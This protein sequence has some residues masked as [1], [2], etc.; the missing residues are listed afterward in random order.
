MLT[1]RELEVL[2]LRTRGKNQKTIAKELDI[3]Q[4]A[5]SQ[6]EKSAKDKLIQAEK[7]RELLGKE[8]ISVIESSIG[9]KVVWGEKK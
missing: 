8:G 6:F 9:K 4:A 3:S 2:V 5:V 1:E 7:T